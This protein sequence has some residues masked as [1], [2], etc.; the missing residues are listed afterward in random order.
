MFQNVN[1]LERTTCQDAPEGFR[2]ARGSAFQTW[3][4]AT[5]ES[6][7]SDLVQAMDEGKNLMTLKYARMDNLIPAL[8]LS[9][10]IDEIVKIEVLWQEELSEKYPHVVILGQTSGYCGAE[11]SAS[12]ITF[13][14]YLR[15]ELETYSQHTLEF[16]YQDV[17]KALKEK[18]NLQERKYAYLVESMGYSSLEK[19]EEKI[20]NRDESRSQL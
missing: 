8:N 10:L 12:H 9:P 3:S 4:E 18:S 14:I 13:D 5:L 16:Y 7:Y 19:V 6:Y 2:L 15:C 1:T 20:M 17:S 11:E